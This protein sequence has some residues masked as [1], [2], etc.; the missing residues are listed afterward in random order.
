MQKLAEFSFPDLVKPPPPARA[1]AT[2][3]DAAKKAS[4]EHQKS[5]TSMI[6]SLQ[7][8]AD[9]Y[10]MTAAQV[11]IYEAAKLG[12]TKKELEQAKAL[13]ES[14]AARKDTTDFIREQQEAINDLNST[15]A[16]EGVRA[17]D[18]FNSRLAAL[19][20]NTTLVKTKT[21]HENVSLLDQALF[22][23]A[24]SA[25]QHAEAL[26]NLTERLPDK[27]EKTKSLAEELGLTFESA[28]ENALVGGKHV[29]D[30]LKG[31]AQDMLRLFA[32]KAI[33][34]PLASWAGKFAANLFP[35]AN[36][37]VFS[38]APALSTYSGT[39]QTSPFI[40]PFANG[41]VPNWGVGAEAGPEA[42]LPLKRGRGGKL[43]VAMEG[44]GGELVYNDNRVYNI[45]ARGAEAGT[46]QRIRRAIDDSEDRAVS[47]AVTQVQNMNQRG[48][49]RLA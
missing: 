25:E 40:F 35:S 17:A 28:F 18:A 38:N 29:S 39:V 12:M 26:A 2:A 6:A 10:G 7:E 5:I 8:E 44:G 3:S 19:V 9:T 4:E 21:L 15:M 14:T 13:I 42:I 11:K 33:T 20:S 49:L 27:L 23:G 1:D 47:R 24:I 34:E 22:D 16:G 32:R 30:M 37:N 41:G 43:G 45:D 36:G 48:Q 46:E 31:L